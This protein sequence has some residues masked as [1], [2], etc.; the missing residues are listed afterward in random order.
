M[1]KISTIHGCALSAWAVAGLTGNNLSE[2]ILKNTNN[3]YSSVFYISVIF[4]L[5]A[6]G[7]CC[8]I[9]KN[10]EKEVEA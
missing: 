2:I 8:F 9:V 3:D 1:K 5:I 7:A 6:F 4:Y 10:K